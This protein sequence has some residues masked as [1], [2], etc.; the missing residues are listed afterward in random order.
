MARNGTNIPGHSGILKADGTPFCDGITRNART[1]WTIPTQPTPEAH[2][3]TF[4]EAL[5]EPCIK[6]GTSE[7]GCCAKCGAP[8]ERVVEKEFYGNWEH[9]RTD[10]WDTNVHNKGHAT[11]KAYKP[12]KT[13]GWQPT[14]KCNADTVPCVVL[15]P[16]GG[17]GTT[18][19]VARDLK[20]DAIMIELNPAY[21]KIMRNKLRLNEQLVT[22]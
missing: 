7:R 12:P 15:D 20:R 5:V 22:A 14:C 21:V 2:F 13:T 8:M 11:D 10:D 1:V 3:A 17:S 18:A 9:H 6:A 19:K 4:P 16:F